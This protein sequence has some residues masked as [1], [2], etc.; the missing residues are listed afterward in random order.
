MSV[1][2]LTVQ[3]VK[4]DI[5]PHNFNVMNLVST[6][7]DPNLRDYSGRKA[8]QYLKNSASSKSQRKRFLSSFASSYEPANLVFTHSNHVPAKT[9]SGSRLCISD[10]IPI[11]N[12]STV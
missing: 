6:E 7:A 1:T 10:P 8:K 5:Q 11:D 9:K 3:S 12:S 2:K 4:D